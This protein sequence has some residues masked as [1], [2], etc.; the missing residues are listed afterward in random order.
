MSSQ[1]A[2]ILYRH[3]VNGKSGDV[4]R[5]RGATGSQELQARTYNWAKGK[6]VSNRTAMTPNDNQVLGNV[7]SIEFLDKPSKSLQIKAT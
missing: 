7:L 6:Y 3:M 2:N 1:M 5:R 4:K